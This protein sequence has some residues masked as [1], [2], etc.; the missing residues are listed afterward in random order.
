MTQLL[1]FAFIS[2]AFVAL[3]IGLLNVLPVGVDLPSG[4]ADAITLIYG[5]MQLFN[6]FLPIDTLVQVLLAALVFQGA[7][8]AWHITRWVIA[9]VAT[10]V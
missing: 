9:V 5:Y 8:L 4:I 6:F 1:Y 7:I 10:W 2:V 3:F